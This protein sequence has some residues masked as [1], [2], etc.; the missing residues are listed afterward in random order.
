MLDQRGYLNR[1]V[2]TAPIRRL[3]PRAPAV[4]GGAIVAVVRVPSKPLD[5]VLEA[6]RRFNREQA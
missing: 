6:A 3:L 5:D 2:A 4:A 1:I